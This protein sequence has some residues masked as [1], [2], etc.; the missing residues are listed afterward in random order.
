MEVDLIRAAHRRVPFAPFE[1]RLKNGARFRVV[2]PETLYVTDECL[3]AP[4]E[5]GY[6]AWIDPTAVVTLQPIRRTNSKSDGNSR[7]KK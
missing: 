2:H 7:G 4:D 5:N 6:P 1:L 3:V